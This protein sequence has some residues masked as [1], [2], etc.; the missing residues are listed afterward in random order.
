MAKRKRYRERF[1]IGTRWQ[2]DVEEK[3]LSL[4]YLGPWYCLT[5]WYVRMNRKRLKENFFSSS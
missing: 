4:P 1:S 3:E 5:N 2:K